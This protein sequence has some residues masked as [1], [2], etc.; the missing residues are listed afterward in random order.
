MIWLFLIT[1]AVVR[2]LIGCVDHFKIA[3]LSSSMSGL[4]GFCIISFLIVSPSP[5][6][7]IYVT[8]V[9][10]SFVLRSTWQPH[11]Q[12]ST[13]RGTLYIMYRYPTRRGT[14]YIMYIWIPRLALG[15]PRLIHYGSLLTHI[16]NIFCTLLNIFYNVWTFFT[17]PVSTSR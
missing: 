9:S 7:D 14:L 3:G 11:L 10:N 13:R 12:V 15:I 2:L 8:G 16:W 17:C 4:T 6:W 1:K 5:S